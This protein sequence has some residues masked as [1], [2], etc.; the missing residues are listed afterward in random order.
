M[1]Q[2]PNCRSCNHCHAPEESFG[3]EQSWCQMRRLAI[4][5]ELA[6]DL[7][8]HHWTPRPPRLPSVDHSQVAIPIPAN[9]QLALTDLLVAAS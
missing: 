9:R 8:C 7:W 4:H 6:A 3:A 1:G 5:P 2:R